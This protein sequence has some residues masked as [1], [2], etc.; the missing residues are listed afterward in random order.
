MLWG[1]GAVWNGSSGAARRLLLE[2]EGKLRGDG[3][4]WGNFSTCRHAAAFPSPSGE[5]AEGG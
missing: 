2:G 1:D 5:G 4:V 3:A